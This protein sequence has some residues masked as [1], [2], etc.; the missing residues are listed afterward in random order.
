MIRFL[1]SAIYLALIVYAVID[2]IN[3]KRSTEQ[4]LIWILVILLFPVLGAILYLL[5]SRGVIKL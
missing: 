2:L 3:S 4:K 5:V 1:I